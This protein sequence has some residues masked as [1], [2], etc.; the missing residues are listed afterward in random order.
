MI[1]EN[2]NLQNKR[3]VAMLKIRA[4]VLRYAREWLDEHGYV[5]VQ[6]P[7]IIPGFGME[8]G[9]FSVKYFDQEAYLVRGLHPYASAFVASLGKIYTVAPFFRAEKVRTQRHLTEYWRIEIAQQCELDAIIEVQ[10]KLIGHVCRSLSR[11]NEELLKCFDR[12]IADLAELR[13]PF[14]KLTYDEVVEILQRDGFA[15][16]WGQKIAQEMERHLS[17][18]FNSPFFVTK[19]PTASETFLYE[20]DSERPELSLSVDLLAPEGFGEI[21]GGAQMIT[22]KEVILSK[23]AEE[24]VGVADQEWY[25]G[26]IQDGLV[27][28]SEFAIGVE[29]LV[30]WIC[31]L[32]T[33]EEAVAFPRLP[34]SAYP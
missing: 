20:L 22:Q 27:P 2:R 18:K 25:L 32:T 31:K 6:G 21:G 33:I 30:Q 8:S 13:T 19:V 1:T 34:G 11:E 10:E 24:G 26:L 3:T 9:S 28:F 29:R 12:S 23:M 4:Q 16:F 14:C 15:V 7:T 17:L 5:E